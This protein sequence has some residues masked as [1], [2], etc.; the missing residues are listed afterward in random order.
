MKAAGSKRDSCAVSPSTLRTERRKPPTSPSLPL[1]P[2]RLKRQPSGRL[3]LDSLP[4]HPCETSGFQ[5]RLLSDTHS[6]PTT[7]RPSTVLDLRDEVP[8]LSAPLRSDP[9]V[10]QSVENRHN[11]AA[12]AVITRCSRGTS[13]TSLSPA[14]SLRQ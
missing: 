8:R 6:C 7:L 4:C 12:P 5:S 10:S 14:K 2:Q 13:V 1:S 9:S 3:C 11:A